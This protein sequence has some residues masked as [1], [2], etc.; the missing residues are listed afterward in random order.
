M[1]VTLLEAEF[2]YERNACIPFS[3]ITKPFGGLSNM[4]PGFPLEV[5]GILIPTSEALYQCCRFPHMPEVQRLI[6]E[7]KNPWY[8][9][10][11]SRVYLKESREDWSCVR[12]EIMDWV[13]RVKLLQ[14]WDE[15][16]ELLLSTKQDP[17]VEESIKDGFWGATPEGDQILV[18]SNV[19][20]RILTNLRSEL[21]QHSIEHFRQI[22]PPSQVANFKIYGMQIGG[23]SK[24]SIAS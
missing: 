8:A 16:G 24:E 2:V 6:I 18:G 1:T 7:Q 20:G 21:L 4:A 9:K 13:Q 14:H 3:K 5:N 23:V 12:V 10:R 17:I 19:L 22:K 15:F 11:R